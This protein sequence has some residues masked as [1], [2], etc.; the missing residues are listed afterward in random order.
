MARRGSVLVNLLT[1]M[2]LLATCCVSAAYAAVLANPYLPFNPFPPPTSLPIA[3]TA[4]PS[5][6]PITS[7]FPTAI[8]TRTPTLPAATSAPAGS[9][10]T[11][12]AQI[13]EVVLTV[14]VTPGAPESPT[15]A[16]ARLAEAR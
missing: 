12:L 10:P 3:V 4:T 5:N 16:G 7:N 15:E 6:T 8:P 9:T 11:P 14:E 1:A 2:A 13:T